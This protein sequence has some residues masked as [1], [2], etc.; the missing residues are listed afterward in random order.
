MLSLDDLE[1]L[2]RGLTRITY[3]EFKFALQG[4]LGHRLDEEYLRPRWAAFED[5]PVGFMLS[6]NPIEQGESLLRIAVRHVRNEK[7]GA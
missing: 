4:S 2:Q 6:R 5:N 1:R 7:T 3:D